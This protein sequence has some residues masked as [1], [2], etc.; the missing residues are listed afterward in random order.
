MYQQHL[1]TDYCSKH[2]DLRPTEMIRSEEHVSK[3]IE[4]FLGFMNPYDR[5]QEKLYCLSS[6]SAAAAEFENYILL[7]DDIGKKAKE[8]FI[9]ERLQK[10]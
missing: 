3:T 6:G 4:A 1:L 2:R 8:T 5:E 10:K 9:A 7:A